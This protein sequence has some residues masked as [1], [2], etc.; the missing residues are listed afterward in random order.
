MPSTPPLTAHY[1]L[2]PSAHHR[3]ALSHVGKADLYEVRLGDRPW[4]R[5][6]QHWTC[7]VGRLIAQG[8]RQDAVFEG[9]QAGGKLGR[10]AAGAQAADVRFDGPDRRRHAEDL[11]DAARFEGVELDRAEAVSVDV[12]NVLRGN[13]GSSEGEADRA[14]ESFAGEPAIEGRAE[15]GDFPQDV[16]AA[17][18]RVFELFRHEDAAAFSEGDPAAAR[19]ERFDS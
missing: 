4:R 10:A 1:L 19:I 15:A 5:Q 9:K 6:H 7:G 11:V 16:R 13:T 12:V 8:W 17:S 2:P 18:A 14:G 3:C